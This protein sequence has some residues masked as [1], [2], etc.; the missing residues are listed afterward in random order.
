M[1]PYLTHAE[2]WKSLWPLF[3]TALL[4]TALL[5]AVMRPKER[6]REVALLLLAFSMLGLVAGYL[7]GFSRSPAVGAVLPAVLSLVGGLAVFL[8]EKDARSRTTVSLS[9]LVFSIT[10]LVGT[11]WG[12]IMRQAAED[13]ATSEPA[14]KQRA[15]LEAEVREFREA[16]GLRPETDFRRTTKLDE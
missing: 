15:L 4:L 2:N 10:L 12:A 6:K 11:S 7:T 14:L 3:V 8:M 1:P 5:Y 13:Y 16:L 9:V